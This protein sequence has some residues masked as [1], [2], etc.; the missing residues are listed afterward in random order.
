MIGP[1][2]KNAVY[3]GGGSASLRPYYAI[4]P[5]DGIRSQAKDVRYSIGAIGYKKLPLLTNI[6]KTGGGKRGMTMKVFL[7]P[8]SNSKRKQVD[9]VYVD[10]SDIL[11]VDYQHPEIQSALYYINMEGSLT[12]DESGDYVFGLAVAGTGKLYIDEKL[13][14][15]NETKQTAGD[16]FFGAGTIEE[17]GSTHLEAKKTY[18]VLVQYG[19]APTMTVHVSG[20]TSMGAGGLRMGG[21]LMTEAKAE[22]EKAVALA[23]EVDQVVICAGLNVSQVSTKSFLLASLL[24][25]R[26]SQI[27]NPRATIVYT[28]TFLRIPMN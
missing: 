21:V 4:T 19:T 23:K 8:P 10:S 14:V 9:E 24:T 18:K 13:V 16:S 6:T 17:R 2:A 15:D 20:V 3:C 28:W 1:N 5:F 11:L 22:I 26:H 27:G 7:E 12:P 25:P